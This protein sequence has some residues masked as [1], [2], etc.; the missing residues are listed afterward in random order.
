M[1][2]KST[3]AEGTKYMGEEPHFDSTDACSRSFPFAT[4]AFFARNILFT[5][6]QGRIIMKLITS[7]L[8]I[9]VLAA[10]GA[11]PAFCEG[12]AGRIAG[13]VTGEVLSLA[14]SAAAVV[15]AGASGILFARTA[16]TFRETGEFLT[17]LGTAIEDRR[18]TRDELAAIVREAKDIFRIWK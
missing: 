4:F 3:E 6:N 15:I 9:A 16:R 2:R 7:G 11:A 5:F 13:L 8:V 14:L 1:R 17:T 10:L 12:I 18:I